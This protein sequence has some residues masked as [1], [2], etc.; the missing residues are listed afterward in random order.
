MHLEDRNLGEIYVA[1]T[2]TSTA[3]LPYTWEA[4]RLPPL[5]PFYFCLLEAHVSSAGV[6]GGGGRG[7]MV[8]S[9]FSSLTPP[10]HLIPHK[11]SYLL[12]RKG[13]SYWL[14]SLTWKPAP[15]CARPPPATTSHAIILNTKAY[16]KA[17]G[18]FFGKEEGKQKEKKPQLA[19]QN[20]HMKIGFRAGFGV[21][22]CS[23][24]AGQQQLTS[25]L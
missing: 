5:S 16:R 23:R 13:D 18:H 17:P 15:G 21:E 1:V 2:I 20:S 14:T 3:A 6:G 11:Q 4:T 8:I 22:R 7:G 19:F 25:L 10:Q 9:L 24:R 12:K